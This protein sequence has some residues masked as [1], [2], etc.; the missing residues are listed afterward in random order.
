[1]NFSWNAVPNV[2]TYRLEVY[3]NVSGWVS[4]IDTQVTMTSYT[5]SIGFGATQWRWRVTAIGAGNYQ[6]STP[7]EWRYFSFKSPG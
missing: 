3:E 6:S 7:S 2:N 1:M 4:R 5:Q